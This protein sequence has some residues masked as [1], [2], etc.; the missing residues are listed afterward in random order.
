M[1]GGVAES[2]NDENAVTIM[3]V[4]G[5]DT[6]ARMIGGFSMFLNREDA[7]VLYVVNPYRPWSRDVESVDGTLSAILRVSHLKKFHIFQTRTWA[8]RQRRRN[9]PPA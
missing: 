9:L 3:D 2:L 8:L 5:N 4:G 7:V 1:V 6:G